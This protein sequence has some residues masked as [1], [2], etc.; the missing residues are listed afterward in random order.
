MLVTSFN[1]SKQECSKF[2]FTETTGAYSINNSGGWGSPNYL[3][4]D[5]EDSYITIKNI[6]TGIQYTQVEVTPSEDEVLEIPFQD[7]II[8][9]QTTPMDCTTIKDGIYHFNYFILFDNNDTV[10]ANY[11]FLS[12]CDLECKIKKLVSSFINLDCKDCKKETL[13][14]LYLEVMALYQALVF[15]YQ[16]GNFCEF[17]K[18]YRNLTKLLKTHNCKNC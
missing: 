6:T 9:G 2:L 5:V 17:N 8:Q 1:V 16:C 13:L 3:I 11:Y 7:L 14:S 4:S 12:L 15:S 10:V 18:V